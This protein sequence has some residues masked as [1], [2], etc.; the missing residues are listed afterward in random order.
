MEVPTGVNPQKWVLCPGLERV[1]DTCGVNDV[2]GD[3]VAD[4]VGRN[5]RDKCEWYDGE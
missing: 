2:D 3:G 1:S 5:N 4:R